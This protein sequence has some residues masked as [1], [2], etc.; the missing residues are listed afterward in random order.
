ML[1]VVK[2]HTG[3]TKKKKKKL[4]ADAEYRSISATLNNKAE[5]SR[6]EGFTCP[7]RSE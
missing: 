7:N 6:N 2:M 1:T 4:R 5:K 3:K